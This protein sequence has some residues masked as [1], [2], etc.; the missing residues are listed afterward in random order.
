MATCGLLGASADNGKVRIREETVYGQ[1]VTGNPKFDQLRFS[2][3]SLKQTTATQIPDEITGLADTTDIVR[4]SVGADGDIA[5]ALSYQSLG[6]TDK[7]MDILWKAAFRANAPGWT[8]RVAL[9]DTGITFESTAT[10]G[11]NAQIKR[12]AGSFVTDG[13]LANRVIAIQG[14]SVTANNCFARI[15]TVAALVLDVKVLNTAADFTDDLT[16]GE[17]VT[18]VQGPQIVNG[19]LCRAYNIEVEFTDLTNVFKVILGAVANTFNLTVPLD[20]SITGSIGFLGSKEESRTSTLGDGSP[21][22]SEAT[23]I[24]SSIDNVLTFTENLAEFDILSFAVNGNNNLRARRNVGDRSAASIGSGRLE[25]TGTLT[26]FFANSTFYD[27]YLAFTQ[28]GFMVVFRDNASNAYVLDLPAVK[29]TAGKRTIDGPNTDVI[30]D[31]GFG[32]KRH[33]TDGFMVRLTRFDAA[34]TP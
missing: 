5:F 7:G 17:S 30:A 19:T 25:M 14:S 34:D 29:L 26:A 24:M 16:A 33:P 28:T 18:V 3:E 9:T 20:G 15:M 21:A 13:F 12:A 31:M 23:D 10:T 2:S 11:P 32:V 6:A 1:E 8:A 22:I 27:K 4:S